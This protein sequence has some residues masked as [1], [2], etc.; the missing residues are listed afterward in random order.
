V[1]RWR[2]H[3]A[4]LV[5]WGCRQSG[6]NLGLSL[7]PEHVGPH[8]C[9]YLPIRQCVVICVKQET[10]QSLPVDA[11]C[12]SP[13]R[14]HTIELLSLHAES[15]NVVCRSRADNASG[16]GHRSLLPDH[17]GNGTAALARH[18][19]HG[20]RP[21]LQDWYAAWQTGGRQAS[22]VIFRSPACLLS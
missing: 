18:M 10:T 17:H 2:K 8:A 13:A 19:G 14:L 1:C 12:A 3:P 16:T 22:R 20:A 9:Q 4:E 11:S 21:P 7:R 6:R 5:W 15:M